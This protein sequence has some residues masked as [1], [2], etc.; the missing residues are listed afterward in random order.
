M[1]T[2]IQ[3]VCRTQAAANSIG[4]AQSSCRL[5]GNVLCDSVGIDIWDEAILDSGV[6]SGEYKLYITEIT[7]FHDQGVIITVIMESRIFSEVV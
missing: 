1:I 6:Q 2:G 4:T 7:F 3:K 5:I